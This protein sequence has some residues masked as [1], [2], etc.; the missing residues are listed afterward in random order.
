MMDERQMH[1]KL[2]KL[3]LSKAGKLETMENALA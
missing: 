1:I 3:K 2:T